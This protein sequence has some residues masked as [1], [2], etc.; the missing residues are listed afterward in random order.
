MP[1]Q[2]R[3]FCHTLEPGGER[4]WKTWREPRADGGEDHG[5]G[6]G[7]GARARPAGGRDRRRCVQGRPG[8][9]PD[10]RPP[11]RLASRRALRAGQRP[12]RALGRHPAPRARRVSSPGI[13]C[14]SSSG[15]RRATRATP[16]SP[17]R[18][19]SSRSFCPTPRRRP[20][21]GRRPSAFARRSAT[22]TSRSARSS[23]PATRLRG[24]PTSS[25]TECRTPTAWS[26]S[27]T[28]AEA[29]T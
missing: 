8:A 16:A 12:R 27:P 19:T 9:S 13:S 14:S 26:G 20:A 4:G 24:R 29:K 28:G 1:H 22:P 18:R 11:A 21:R 25:A 6:S 7:V 10:R 17:R 5:R 15:P 2:V 23:G 3:A